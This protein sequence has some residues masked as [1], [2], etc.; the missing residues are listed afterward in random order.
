MP[1]MGCSAFSHEPESLGFDDGVT[2]RA[3]VAAAVA[4]LRAAPDVRPLRCPLLAGSGLCRVYEARPVAC[5][6]YGFYA[7]RDGVLGCHRIAARAED[8]CVTWD[9][10]EAATRGLVGLGER[11]SLLDWPAKAPDLGL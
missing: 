3:S 10:H 5:R 9:N 8:P 11:R 6:S 2:S 1:Y 7:D 4:A